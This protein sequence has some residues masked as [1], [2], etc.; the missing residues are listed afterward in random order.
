VHVVK[1]FDRFFQAP[2]FEIMQTSLPK[3]RQRIVADGECQI[4]LCGGRSLLAPQA[5]RDAL[6][7]NLNR[8]GGSSFDRL[9]DEQMEM[10]RHDDVA[11]QGE[12]VPVA[13]LP[14]S[15]DENASGANRAQQGQASVT[16]ERIEMQMAA[17]VVAN[18]FVGHGREEKSNLRPF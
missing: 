15:V 17:S 14:Q 2:D 10:L 5:P 18:E 9:A 11:H 4:Q 8:S 7:Q 12:P 16:S 1:L 13:H 3:A 6:F